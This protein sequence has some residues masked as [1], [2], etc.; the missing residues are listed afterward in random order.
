MS[1]NYAPEVK[2]LIEAFAPAKTKRGMLEDAS[3]DVPTLSATTDPAT[4]R[5]DKLGKLDDLA[6]CFL[7]VAAWVQ[8]EAD[9]KLIA[10]SNV[11]SVEDVESLISRLGKRP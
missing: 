8:W 10:E 3:V 11:G 7:Q 5:R 6:D 1:L 4:V 9:R 2:S